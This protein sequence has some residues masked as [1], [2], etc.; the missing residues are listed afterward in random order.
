MRSIIY[1]ISVK[2]LTIQYVVRRGL[3]R[4]AVGANR[5]DFL[6]L[7]KGKELNTPTSQPNNELDY[8][9]SLDSKDTS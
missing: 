5:I 3:Y 9:I 8:P 4:I 2:T 6:P 1:I 7:F